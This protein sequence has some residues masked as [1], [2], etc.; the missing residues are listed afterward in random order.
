ML[1]RTP[2]FS[3]FRFGARFVCLAASILVLSACSGPRV[4]M[5]T[6]N[7]YQG[8]NAQTLFSDLPESLRSNEIDL[9]YITDRLPEKDENGQLIYGYG[10]SYSL[11]FGSAR[12]SLLPEMSWAA[13]EQSSLQE[14]R[15]PEVTIHLAGIEE[16]GRF[17]SSPYS[18]V[19]KDGVLFL[20][21]ATEQKM[22]V[23]V[24]QFEDA[25]QERLAVSPKNEVVLFVHGFNN[26]FEYAAGTAAEL[27]HFLGR[28]HVQV[29]YTWPAGRGGARGYTYDRESGEFTVFHLKK[30]IERIAATPGV[31]KLHLVGHSRGTD[32]L[33]TAVRELIFEYRD[34]GR[35]S[36]PFFNIENV[37]L[38]AP[39]LDL[40][41]T[42]QRLA[43]DHLNE[44]VGDVVFYTF[45]GD[46]A[47]GA[48]AKL[49]R[50]KKR[51]GQ[52]SLDDVPEERKRLLTQVQGL[53]FVE[54]EEATDST[55]HGYFHS[56]PE[57]SSDLIMT[58][59]YDMKPGK[60]NGRPLTPIAP[61]FWKMNTGY[62]NIPAEN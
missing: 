12:F 25:L 35:L 55:G 27:W 19:R 49:F 31:E 4:L 24:G 39:D 29:L 20:E 18:A 2:R 10:R 38:A 52:V 59:R 21:P 40:D 62:P 7:V 37:V 1:N 16:I 53:S 57:A 44:D 60:E 9:F 42:L 14:S 26:D 51:M 5:P 48:S 3:C 50:S 36:V 43:A 47:I 34:T 54:L 15:D 46:K 58:I 6:P 56:S 11:A 17:P 30:T 33:S 13:L 22:N 41:V 61:L 8:E 23:A 32:V 28:E 45:G